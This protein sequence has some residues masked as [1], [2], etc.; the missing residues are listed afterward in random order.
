MQPEHERL[1]GSSHNGKIQN[2]ILKNASR[3][4]AQYIVVFTLQGA[5]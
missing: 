4:S 2:K 3:N 1:H 5:I